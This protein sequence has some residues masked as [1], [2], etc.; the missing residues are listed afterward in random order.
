[1]GNLLQFR[2]KAVVQVA[3]IEPDC[4]ECGGEGP[5]VMTDNGEMCE[6]CLMLEFS[7]D[8]DEFEFLE[9]LVR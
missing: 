1:M 2:T 3:A 4:P 6:G 5:L 8:D 7:V 9:G